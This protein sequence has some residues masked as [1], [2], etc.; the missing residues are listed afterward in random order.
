M[1]ISV[2][3]PLYNKRTTIARAIESVLEQSYTDWELII[4][5]D[6]STDGSDK[7]VQPYL[8]DYR[9]KYI[10]KTNGGVSSARN[11]GIMEAT[12]E[13]GCY[14]D[15]DDYFLPEGLKTM[16]ELAQRYN[17]KVATGRFL[18]DNKN[19]RFIGVNGKKEGILENNF[20][21]WFFNRSIPRAGAAIFHLELLKKHLFDETLSRYEDAKSLF[22][23]L[24]ENEMAYTPIDVMVYSLD[25]R[26][27]SNKASEISQD[28]IFNMNFDSKPYWE[29]MLLGNL[30]NQGIKLYPEYQQYLLNRYSNELKWRN[31][32]KWCYFINKIIS[33]PRKIVNKFNL[34]QK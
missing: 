20:K 1:G 26:N 4:I 16:V 7:I 31:K 27:L 21:E 34:L 32:A 13:W 29:K 25:N 22:E 10:Y 28:F 6:G 14:I 19:K 2:I 24:R 12:G 15:A 33:M 5:D 18:I 17:V 23:I 11:R 8:N 30:L 9:I 3:I